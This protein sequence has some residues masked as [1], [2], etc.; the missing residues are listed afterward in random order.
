MDLLKKFRIIRKTACIWT[1][2]MEEELWDYCQGN[3]LV[4]LPDFLMID[5]CCYSDGL[6]YCLFW[7]LKRLSSF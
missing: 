1:K 2:K 3:L 6:R 4:S 7:H 5:R